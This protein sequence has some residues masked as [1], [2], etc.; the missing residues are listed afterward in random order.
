VREDIHAPINKP[1]EEEDT[2]NRGDVARDILKRLDKNDC[3][4]SFG[5]YG[6][7]GTGK[8][9]LLNLL[10]YI[11]EHENITAKKIRF[12]IIDA[13]QYEATNSLFV[14]I[15]TRLRSLAK[16]HLIAPGEAKTYFKRVGTVLLLASSDVALRKLGITLDDVKKYREEIH[17][18]IRDNESIL[19]WETLVDDVEQTKHAFTRLVQLVLDEQKTDHL[20]LCIDNLDRCWPENVISLLESIQNFLSVPQ[21]T[22]II[23]VDSNVIASY[24]DHKYG[25][26]DINGYSYL[27]K[28]VPE[29]YHLSLG[30]NMDNFVSKTFTPEL[31][32]MV[33]F[34]WNSYA[35]IPQVLAPRRLIK[36]VKKFEAYIQHPIIRSRD[37]FDLVFKLILLYHSWPNFYEHFSSNSAEQIG[38][39]LANFMEKLKLNDVDDIGWKSLLDL[40]TPLAHQYSDDQE[41]IYFLQQA[42]LIPTRESNLEPE[43]LTRDIYLAVTNLRQVGLP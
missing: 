12:E 24:V 36:S 10:K 35:H 1:S 21:C 25:N 8:T 28:I 33:F 20:V 43:G 39:V 13:W 23:A 42:F 37:N 2:L 9:S 41:L 15:I 40:P 29:Q 16:K 32:R 4:T 31:Q 17:K 18:E 22:W 34:D 3:P 30:E 11:S 14:P 6:G 27:D 7:W 19:D 38:K 26:T 5:I